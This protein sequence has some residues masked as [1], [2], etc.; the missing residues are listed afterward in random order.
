MR[1][2]GRPL[3][4]ALWVLLP[5]CALQ[6]WHST[7][8][9]RYLD[10]HTLTE[11]LAE[12]ES[13]PPAARDRPMFLLNRG[14]L[15]HLLGNYQRSNADLEAAKVALEKVQAISVTEGFTS[16]TINETLNDYSAT[17]SERVL[18]HEVMALNYLAANDLAAARV[19][20]LQADLRMRELPDDEAQ[21]ASARFVAGL[22]F[23]LNHEWSDA[24]ISYR[25][26]KEILERRQLAIPA[27]LQTRLIDTSQR[28]GLSDEYQRYLTQFG[29]SPPPL[30]ADYG[31]VL[32]L[33]LNGKVDSMQQRMISLYVPSLQHNVTIADPYY[34][35][36]AGPPPRVALALGSHPLRLELLEDVDG[37]AREAL[38]AG[39]SK[40]IALTLARVTSK[41]QLVKNS[42]QKDPLLGMLADLAAILTEAADTRSWNLLPAAIQVGSIRLPP[43]SYS[44]S[45]GAFIDGANP[46]PV[47][48]VKAGAT[49]LLI[50]NSYRGTPLA[51]Y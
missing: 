26:A 39:Q 1:A 12:L 27:T 4:L 45:G 10:S 13:R 8:I 18:L 24:M 11:T 43:G 47:V 34:P 37:L 9:G 35:P 32:V 3:L 5:G 31:E 16:S 14:V 36:R 28:L 15:H 44:L 25:M 30:P 38:R 29:Q 42:R 19:E 17:P 33:Y 51:F 40:R 23:E 6:Q 46:A 21:L 48:E 7:G 22:I 50:A 41:H 20:A 49:R 2:A